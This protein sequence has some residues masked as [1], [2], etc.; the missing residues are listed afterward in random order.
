[1]SSHSKSN[2]N[3]F[4][5]IT[6]LNEALAEYI[7]YIANQS[8]LS[9]GRFIIALS[10][11]QTPKSL[12]TF[13][14]Q[15]SYGDRIPWSKTFIFFVDERCVPLDDE[16][17]NAYMARTILLDHVGIPSTNIH[18]IPVNLPPEKAAATYEK[19]LTDFFGDQALTFDLILLGLG[20]NGH[21][22]SLFPYTDVLS[23]QSVGIKV[24][25]INLLGDQPEFRISMTAPLINQ[26]HQ[27]VFL[28]TGASKGRILNYVLNGS[29]KPYEY[30]AQL[31]K[32]TD[33]ELWWYTDWKAALLIES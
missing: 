19:T 31:I 13:L 30:P 7:I 2:I 4:E 5:S 21:T 14:A 24:V 9:R 8:I 6:E 32:P 18:V 1:M 29:Y 28:V 26:A 25:N 3:A 12:F 27:I 15:P 33:G 11:G 10:G 23:E 22:A 20:D 17:N 16:R